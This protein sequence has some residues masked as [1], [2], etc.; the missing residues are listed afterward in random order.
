MLGSAQR[1]SSLPKCALP[2]PHL[3]PKPAFFFLDWELVPGRRAPVERRDL[4]TCQVGLP[5]LPRL[6]GVKEHRGSFAP[7]RFGSWLCDLLGDERSR[8][9]RLLGLSHL[10]M[11]AEVAPER[12]EQARARAL[13]PSERAVRF[14][15][16]ASQSE[17]G[18]KEGVAGLEGD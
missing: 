17:L 1:G 16:Q 5:G 8:A 13:S 14:A 2:P 9:A 6:G 10:E 11:L 12:P 15:S 3:I 4:G 18:V 7:S